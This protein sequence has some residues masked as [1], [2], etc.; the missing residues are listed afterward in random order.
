MACL[1][2]ENGRNTGDPRGWGCY[3]RVEEWRG[4][5]GMALRVAGPFGC[6]CPSIPPCSVSTPRSSNRT[7]GFP[8]SGSPTGFRRRPTGAADTAPFTGCVVRA[9]VAES[10]AEVVGN[11]ATLPTLDHFPNAPE[12]RSL[13]SPGITRLPRYYEPVRLPQRPGLSLTG[14]QLAHAATAGGLPRCERSPCVSMPSPLPRWD[15]SGIES[16]P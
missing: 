2:K 5:L 9:A 10:L 6:Q 7:C 14:V 16:L 11:T 8:A 13:P 4:G 3:G 15:R 1:Y 12:V